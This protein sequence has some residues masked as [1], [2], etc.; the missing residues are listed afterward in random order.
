[1]GKELLVYGQLPRYAA[2]LLGMAAALVAARPVYAAAE[3]VKGMGD[4]EIQ[5]IA[6]GPAG[7]SKTLSVSSTLEVPV[8]VLVTQ[9]VG[10]CGRPGALLHTDSKSVPANTPLTFEFVNHGD[11][12]RTALF[13]ECRYSELNGTAA[14]SVQRPAPCGELLDVKGD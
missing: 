8:T 13:S 3:C 10:K 2:G 5:C 7:P 1:M 14:G 12:C 9:W 6:K 4:T 11:N